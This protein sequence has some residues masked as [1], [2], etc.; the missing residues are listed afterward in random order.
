MKN[1]ESNLL[2][3]IRVQQAGAQWRAHV[4]GRS[5]ETDGEHLVVLQG[6]AINRSN[7]GLGSV[8]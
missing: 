7:I 5:Q 8:W 4:P 3:P 6:G 1:D 2:L